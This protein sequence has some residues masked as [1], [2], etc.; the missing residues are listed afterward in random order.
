MIC[1]EEL[2]I[3]L[4]HNLTEISVRV[5]EEIIVM[6]DE[7]SFLDLYANILV[8]ELNLLH[9]RAGKTIL[10]VTDTISTEVII[11]R[12]FIEV[13]AIGL[14][15]SAITVMC[16]NGLI[17]VIPDKSAL[18]ELIFSG[19]ICI[20]EHCSCG[21]THR[22]HVFTADIRFISMTRQPFLDFRNRYIH[23]RFHVREVR[24]TSVIIDTFVVNESCLIPFME[25][26]IL[27]CKDFSTKGLIS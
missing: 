12:A 22:M 23:G 16:R 17:D 1:F 4:N 15:F 21:V 25:V 20:F 13:S 19:Q 18:V 9:L 26:L 10:A 3:L 24:T 14:E 2:A 27:L 6:N 8:E 11:R 5:D 7:A